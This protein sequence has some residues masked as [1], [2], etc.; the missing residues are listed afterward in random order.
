MLDYKGV[1]ESPG[2]AGGGVMGLVGGVMAEDLSERGEWSLDILAPRIS[3]CGDVI[4]RIEKFLESGT[5]DGVFR[6]FY[7]KPNPRIRWQ[8]TTH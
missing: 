7:L 4:E 1:K 6:W 8:I 2:R 5:F 3:C